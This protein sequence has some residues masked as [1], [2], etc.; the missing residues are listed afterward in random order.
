MPNTGFDFDRGML[1]KRD[2]TTGIYVGMYLDTP[3]VYI[4]G[5]GKRVSSAIARDA[6][7]DVAKLD[8]ER[9]KRERL[10][11]FKRDLAAD[12]DLTEDGDEDMVLKELGGY[13]VLRSPSGMVNVVDEDGRRLNPT[14]LSEELGMQ[15][16][17]RLTEGLLEKETANGGKAT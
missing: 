1:I 14:P 9:E 16:V 2:R 17:D 11:A 10:D 7:F 3:G 4:N 6:G 15:L 8:R 13:K 5:H 12:L